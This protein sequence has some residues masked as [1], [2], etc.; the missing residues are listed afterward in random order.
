MLG[1]APISAVPISALGSDDALVGQ[2]ATVQQGSLGVV[3]EVALTGQSCSTQQGTLSPET[4]L[5]FQQ[6]AAV[7]SGTLGVVL[8][9]PLTGQ[10]A[11]AAHGTLSP[12]ISSGALLSGHTATVEQG[13]LRPRMQG[14]T[15]TTA[16]GD[17]GVTVG[18]TLTG[19]VATVQ[20]TS[21]GYINASGGSS[22]LSLISALM[23]AQIGD[24]EPTVIVGTTALATA[25]TPAVETHNTTGG[26]G[27]GAHQARQSQPVFVEGYYLSV[28]E[29]HDGTAD[30][31]STSLV[32]GFSGVLATDAPFAGSLVAPTVGSGLQDLNPKFNGVPVQNFPNTGTEFSDSPRK[33][34]RGGQVGIDE[35]GQLAVLRTRYYDYTDYTYPARRQFY[36]YHGRLN[37]YI[38]RGPEVV[39]E[40]DNARYLESGGAAEDGPFNNSMGLVVL[41]AGSPDLTYA[42][43]ARNAL[44]FYPSYW[45]DNGSENWVPTYQQVTQE[46]IDD[47]ELVGSPVQLTSF[48]GIDRL[49][50][51]QNSLT[52]TYSGFGDVAYI[53]YLASTPL[54]PRTPAYVGLIVINLRTLTV[55]SH[56]VVPLAAAASTFT[57]T[58]SQYEAY[59]HLAKPKAE[60][61]RLSSG[62]YVTQ[63]LLRQFV[64]N[65]NW[66]EHD[67]L[68][69]TLTP[70]P[71]P[72]SS[73][74]GNFLALG[75][76]SLDVKGD[77]VVHTL[78]HV[79]T[80]TSYPDTS[81]SRTFNFRPYTNDATSTDATWTLAG[82]N[83][84]SWNLNWGV[85]Q[86][87]Y[88]EFHVGSKQGYRTWLFQNELVDDLSSTH[89]RAGE[90][91][92]TYWSGQPPIL[93]TES[94]ARVGGVTVSV[95]NNEKSV[96][97]TGFQIGVTA[98][99]TFFNTNRTVALSGHGLNVGYT[100]P[101]PGDGSATVA[102]PSL[103][104]H[105][106]YGQITA[107]NG[108]TEV[109]LTGQSMTTAR[110]N[111]YSIGAILSGHTAT[112]QQGS[113]GLEPTRVRLVGMGFQALYTPI[114]F[115]GASLA[116][117]GQ[118]STATG[119]TL[120][121]E[122]A[123]TFAGLS[124]TATHGSLGPSITVALTGHECTTQ[125]GDVATPVIGA[126]TG[127]EATAQHGALG[128]A[129]TVGLTGQSCTTAYGS[130]G[131]STDGAVSLTG[132]ACSTAG[133]TLSS[134][135]AV[136][137]LGHAAAISQG[138]MGVVLA[139]SLT[140]SGLTTSHAT[141]A[142]T[143]SRVLPGELMTMAYGTMPLVVDNNPSVTGVFATGVVGD[144]TVPRLPLPNS[145][146]LWAV[147]GDGERLFSTT[148]TVE[149][150]F[151]I[152]TP[153]D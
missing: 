88:P 20:S 59:K 29:T 144:I 24:P 96:P 41:P 9:V 90:A 56:E 48:T 71:G 26:G 75:S 70:K 108:V 136:V 130:F 139:P 85:S 141:L 34:G 105:V 106:A 146:N 107:D 126:C 42:L 112:T 22:T 110:G 16:R 21:P 8:E 6:S 94:I 86:T 73:G 27:P 82:S 97:L 36:A 79:G 7:S 114:T 54:A 87:H 60:V 63:F 44:V 102:L 72:V 33:Y 61:V 47:G 11:T 49:Y 133:G 134:A 64:I 39:V 129:I 55:H 115:D 149:E 68:S 113:M 40:I 89:L 109:I 135:T 147:Q 66:S 83:L 74:V 76:E 62:R 37:S 14:H 13:Q 121:P 57:T 132:H 116:L 98:T 140:G 119:G 125:Y 143:I 17:L 58:K 84:W 153:P 38:Y 53:T 142:I 52:T 122:I 128:V 93:G 5:L 46:G 99:H 31:W 18:V 35:D 137:C 100:T 104:T 67:H 4:P 95:A 30:D 65:L 23:S 150:E 78:Y 15:A 101:L 127:H 91:F 50:A 138:D 3:I 152:A 12:E 123:P 103:T 2:Q 81:S 77:T 10:G 131:I 45:N 111:L 124:S 28:G 51:M 1:F 117:T 92:I 145:S 69:P 19:Q 43:Q 32:R 120:V 148:D 118:G 80:G 25:T 151:I